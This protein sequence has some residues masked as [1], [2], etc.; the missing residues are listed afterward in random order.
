M[1]EYNFIQYCLVLLR[2]NKIPSHVCLSILNVLAN[3][4]DTNPENQDLLS[5]EDVKSSVIEHFLI[6]EENLELRNMCCLLLSHLTWNH[7]NNQKLFGTKQIVEKLLQL[8]DKVCNFILLL[9]VI[10]L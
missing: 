8:I 9:I 2:D 4:A 5:T 10:F 1:R 6:Q 7:P 3:F